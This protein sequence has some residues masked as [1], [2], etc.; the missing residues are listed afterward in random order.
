MSQ[1]SQENS[2]EKRGVLD[3]LSSFFNPKR[4]KS[5]RRQQS[6]SSND[7]LSPT[8][9]LS[10]RSP[11][12]EE[13]EEEDGLKT[14]TPSRK[15]SELTLY[16]EART[17]A[18]RGDALSQCSSPSS[19]VSL[20]T[21]ELP[22]A[23]SSSS[24][25]SSMRETYV[26]R[27]S[28]A[29]VERNSGNVTP[30]SLNLATTAHPGPELDL[31]ESVY[32][33]PQ[34]NSDKGVRTN[35]EVS[36]EGTTVSPA[37]LSSFKIPLSAE[38]PKSPNLI[39]IS[40]ASK[41]TSVKVG[42]KGHSTALTGIRL[43]SQSSTS[44]LTKTQQEDEKPVDEEK[45]NAEAK[46]RARL[47]SGEATHMAWGPSPD[48][49]EIA[50][51]DSP[52]QLHKAIWMETHLGEEWE[53]E[54]EGDVM[55]EG[56]EG[57]RAD[58]PPVLAIPV[59][60][61]PEDDSAPSETL[62]PSGSSPV[63]AISLVL[64]A[65][66]GQTNLP[67]SEEPETGTDSQK[68]PP[69]EKRRSRESRVTRKT[70]NLP[71][72][73]KVFAHKV[74]VSPEPGLEG[75][76]PAGEEHSG[77]STSKIS[78][79]TEIKQLPSL[80][81]NN[82][83]ELKEANREPFTTTDETLTDS[84][85]PGLLGEE[86]AD[87]EASDFDDTSAPSDMY[88]AKSK[89]LGSGIRGKET[90][91][92]ISSK[93]GPKAATESR[94][95]TAS[96]AKTPSSAAGSKAKNVTTKAKGS[97]EGTKVG[98]SGDI[99]QQREQ[100]S[101]KTVS[102]L[103][104]LK[105]QSTSASSSAESSKSKIPKR[106][107]SDVDVKS[108][109]TPDKKS[110]SDASDKLQKHPRTKEN[111]KSAVSTS[112]VGRKP[113]F[114]EAKGGKSETRD[115]SPTKTPHK[116]GTKLIKEKSN[117]DVGSNN[118]VNGKEKDYKEGSVKTEHTLERKSLN[119]EKLPQNHLENN[120]SLSSKSRL[121]ISSPTRKNNDDITQ[122]GGTSHKKIPSDLTD[123]DRPNKSSDGQEV[124]FR[125]RPGG[126]R[127]LHVPGSPTKGGILSTTPSK[128]QS[129]RSISHEERDTPTSCVS[130]PPTE[131]DETLRRSKYNKNINQRQKSPVKDSADPLVS[132]S[133][134][135]T[136]GQRSSN[137]INVKKP[138]H[139]E[140]SASTSTSKQDSDMNAQ[141]EEAVKPSDR[142]VADGAK[143]G[144]SDDRSKVKTVSTEEEEDIIKPTDKQSSTSAF[145]LEGK[146]MSESESTTSPAT[147]EISEIQPIQNNDAI[148]TANAQEE[149]TLEAD[150][151]SKLLPSSGVVKNIPAHSPVADVNNAEAHSR[152]IQ[153]EAQQQ[154]KVEYSPENESCVQSDNNA[155][156][157]Q[158]PLLVGDV[159]ET[160]HV[161]SNIKPDLI[162]ENEPKPAVVAQD[163]IPAHEDVTDMSA[164]PVVGDSIHCDIMTH[165]DE[166]GVL[167]DNVSVEATTEPHTAKEEDTTKSL[168]ATLA[169]K[170][171]NN[172]PKDAL[173]AVLV[174]ASLA[175]TE[176]RK[177][178]ELLKDQTTNIIFENDRLPS[179]IGR[180]S[181]KNVEVE[182]I[183]KEEVGRKPPKALHIQTE[184]VTVCELPKN[185]ENKPDKEPLLLA[186]QFERQQKDSKPNEQLNG[187]AVES[188]NSQ[189]S[190][191]EELEGITIED[192]A[193]KNFTKPGKPYHPST[194]QKCVQPDSKEGP[195]TVATDALEEKRTEA[196]QARSVPNEATSRVVDTKHE[197]E[198]LIKENASGSEETQPNEQQ[199]MASTMKSEQE[200]K[201]LLTRDEVKDDITKEEEKHANDVMEIQ[202][203]G[204]KAIGTKMS[205]DA[206]NEIP[207][208]TSN[209]TAEADANNQ[210]DKKALIARDLDED[211]KTTEENANSSTESK[212]PTAN[213]EQ[214][215]EAQKAPEIKTEMVATHEP[216]TANTDAQSGKNTEEKTET[217]NSSVKS[218]VNDTA[219]VTSDTKVSIQQDLASGN[220]DISKPDKNK[221]TESKGPNYVLDQESHD[222][223]EP[224]SVSTSAEDTKK[225]TE[226]MDSSLKS[227]VNENEVETAYLDVC[228]PKDRMSVIGRDQIKDMEKEEKIKTSEPEHP[229]SNLKLEPETI[230]TKVLE[231]ISENQNIKIYTTQEIDSIS[232]GAIDT[233]DNTES[234][235]SLTANSK[236]AK[237]VTKESVEITEDAKLPANSSLSTVASK[238]DEIK[239]QKTITKECVQDQ[240]EVTKQEA[241][242]KIISKIDVKQAS[243]LI[244]V[245]DASTKKVGGE[246]MDKSSVMLNKI[247]ISKDAQKNNEGKKENISKHEFQSL[248]EE[249]ILNLTDP[250]KP[251]KP[252]PNGSL[253]PPATAKPSTSSQSPQLRKESPS[254]WLDV[255]HRQKQKKEH[256]RRLNASASEDESVEPDDFDDFISSIK[257]GGIPFSVPTRR[258]IRK[259]SPS[260]PF[261]MPAIKEDRFERTFDPAEFQ[262]GLRKNGK[263]FKDPSPAMAMKQNAANRE[264][265]TQEKRAQDN[266]LPTSRDKNKSL[267]EVE[268]KEG[269][270]EAT[271]AEARKEEGQ[272]NGEE[273]GKLTS[274]L[275]RMSILSSL[276]SYSRKTKEE[277]NSASNSSFSSSQQRDMPALGKQ[278]A[279]DSL[280]PG[281]GADKEGVKNMDQGPLVGGG[282]GTISESALSPSS[283]PPLP[284]FAE[285]KLPDHLDKYLKK[286]KTESEASKGS[287]QMTKTEL[288]P[289]GS[290]VMDQ[291]LISGVP[292]VD[293]GLKGPAAPPPTTN[294]SQQNSQRRLSTTKK[295]TPVVRGVHKRPGKIVIHEQAQF[296]GEALEFCRDVE[297]ATMMTLSP[298]ISVRVIRGCWLIY[299]K[300]GFQGRLIALEEGPTE[301]I[302]NVWADEGTPTTL[303][304]N[305]QPVPTT[306]MV[307]GSLRLAVKD[308]SMP[309]IDLFSEVNG[310]GRMS[311]YC[312][313]TVEIA[314]YGIP[315]TTGSIKVHSGVWLVYA[316]PGFGGFIGVLEVGEYPCPES[317]GF[318][319]PFIGSLRPLRMG[320]IKV[321][322]PHEVKALV[323]EKPNFEGECIQVDS[324]VY[325][326][327][328][329]EEEETEKRDEN[330]KTLPTVGSL[331]I[332]RGLWV[333]YLEADFEGQQYI[334]E[335]GEYPHCSDWGG[336]EDG[337]LS[338][339]PVC[340]DFLSPH[341]KLFS[342]QNFDQLGLN[343]DL[344]GPILNME[345]IS[346]GVRS[347]SVDVM[348]GVWVAFE[349]PGF[350]GELYVLEKG[351]YANPEDWGAQNFKISSIQP[352]FHEMLMGST[353]FKV[354][355]YSEP[356][357][358][359]R[360]VV[361]EEST[362]ALDDDFM[363]R[364]CKVL[365]GSWVAYEGAQFTET[366]YVL[367]EGEYPNTVAMGFL[368]SES[369]LRSIHTTG[370]EL[371][372]PSITLFSKVGRRGRRVMLTNGVVNLLQA[373]LDTHIRSLVVEGGMWVLYEGSNYRGR[374]LLLQPSQVTDFCKLSNWKQIGSLRPLLQKQMHF[375]LRN[376]ETGCIMSLTGT[377]DDIKLMRVQA[378]DETGGVEQVWLYRDGQ[379]TCKLIEDCCLETS[380]SVVM[381]GSRLCVSPERGKDNQLWNITP[382]G[383]VHS[384]LQPD[385]VLEVKGGQQYDK[386][387]VIL[388]TFDDRKLNQR[389]TLEIL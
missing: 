249:N 336:S 294:Y 77:D 152:G 344:M 165:S 169:L 38:I 283:P 252:K 251:A 232:T 274:R 82:H 254:S 121:P 335:E 380:S 113:S 301:H 297:D 140:N 159:L 71:S 175:N 340:T 84:N 167:P 119:I 262:F 193:E 180:E 255:E 124:P 378:V 325:N 111:S 225:K 265:R 90:N 237:T 2:E 135:P 198:I 216:S 290:A 149:V 45:G 288:N 222:T 72:K 79:P 305:G 155:Q 384:H 11:Q 267:D 62:P 61:I 226:I 24:G 132:V 25:R 141:P 15:G 370:H 191:K 215:P 148:I 179:T 6:D 41:K 359:G 357:F 177:E 39:S 197:C 360:L 143:D 268:G 134:L 261:A 285:I 14:P 107:T 331:K 382:D 367:E 144:A 183:H 166:D 289:E 243:E 17:G 300:P 311:S 307:I 302:V 67:Q 103:P 75:S 218:L 339:R 293:V 238:S 318:S 321:E 139:S 42:K 29:S 221:S 120:A 260:P 63:T 349:K 282:K 110:V 92:T 170:D 34:V 241:E 230:K 117:E 158:T 388:N 76:G 201:L 354:Q 247:P 202:T 157:Q 95:T 210:A 49:G 213:V 150:P 168:P 273:P 364:S 386:N 284:Q 199:T 270:K 353:K 200:P 316:D 19:I 361:L 281:A 78:D 334:L 338:L 363:P 138:Q 46:R 27:V 308:Y 233:K 115:I 18:E 209:E 323:F 133:K 123:S 322:H 51:G 329:Q 341:V 188:A 54:K 151:A 244:F 22:F 91:K 153:Q 102:V 348:G 304:Q 96:E 298:V 371:S 185:V 309:R 74:Y 99:P 43:G 8:S 203:S 345:D 239:K 368:S 122:T 333:G 182:E 377:L 389:W 184:A 248:R 385:L 264:G 324:D 88:K 317:W 358:Q 256:K 224:K 114:E 240:D 295:K 163:T 286:N 109:G 229:N 374:Q 287:T 235:K 196:E 128:H 60:V 276:R 299:E 263:I 16:G 108:P 194:E 86:K 44:Q 47:F 181:G 35:A 257:R 220:K 100:R 195:Q 296:G 219:I 3:R 50:R 332:L 223:Q 258:N 171:Q 355:L 369:T 12:S 312:D 306:P 234:V 40:L 56:E 379:L 89:D 381:A 292:T 94:H 106:T 5:I 31:V 343:A 228:N 190:C 174:D 347:Q 142:I 326:L 291:A 57:F 383:L 211:I 279:A 32:K 58:S 80:Q 30:T 189:S 227:L 112:K 126:E 154:V 356:G 315:Q 105:D 59:T 372:L 231:K 146:E 97:T 271:K 53:G 85:T 320:A 387:Q 37:T 87:S 23:D 173:S 70:V 147:R 186:E 136:L 28:T 236:E 350:S 130:P 245:K 48:R 83:A 206:G 69:R 7:A 160:T 259:K 21:D 362:A 269:V 162:Q 250:Q 275:E 101:E 337:L 10:P 192:K 178:N 131:P 73:H 314:S 64:T 342:E 266:A 33:E 373:G 327:Q 375:L 205:E 277:T 214:K 351:L 366:M 98:A 1:Q 55:E 208:E 145:R 161:I 246:Q 116:T 365:A 68:S 118:L 81:S 13:E 310:M 303:D 36:T 93:P 52:V 20:S 4:K 313:D 376:K 319:E 212:C 346:H 26:C 172:G 156:G 204:M 328:E 278:G 280:L 352:V 164:K 137:K 65:G 272:G 104:T 207:N 217:M 253:F 129:N 9:P 330:K 66:E 125:E 127:P 176:Q 242:Q 187:A